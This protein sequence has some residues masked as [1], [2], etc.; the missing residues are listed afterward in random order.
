MA[1]KTRLTGSSQSSHRRRVVELATV[2]ITLLIA[3]ATM[4]ATRADAASGSGAASGDAGAIRRLGLVVEPMQPGRTLEELREDTV[5]RRCPEPQCSG[6]GAA[7]WAS[8][9]FVE[10]LSPAAL[11]HGGL[12]LQLSLCC[13][14]TFKR[15]FLPDRADAF[16]A[17]GSRRG[18]SSSKVPDGPLPSDRPLPSDGPFIPSF[19]FAPPSE[20]LFPPPT[21]LVRPPAREQRRTIPCEGGVPFLL[22]AV[23]DGA[24]NSKTCSTRTA[25]TRGNDLPPQHEHNEQITGSPKMLDNNELAPY[26]RRRQRL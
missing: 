9:S 19:L 20:L 18:A 11:A 10:D 22:S 7:V 4:G 12:T 17:A 8:G 2:T 21:W 6:P 1:T 13:N 25:H 15:D 14:F 26:H 23:I 16:L 3:A 24:E 5:G